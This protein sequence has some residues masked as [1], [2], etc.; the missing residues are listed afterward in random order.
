MP[1]KTMETVSSGLMKNRNAKITSNLKFI[2]VDKQLHFQLFCENY[3]LKQEIDYN[4]MFEYPTSNQ[5]QFS[6]N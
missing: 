6:N 4:Q 3:Q 5:D 2:I 1:N